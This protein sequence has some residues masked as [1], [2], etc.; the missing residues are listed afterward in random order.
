M[1]AMREKVVLNE[2]ALRLWGLVVRAP[3]RRSGH[4]DSHRARVARG[5]SAE[6]VDGMM[7]E[8]PGEAVW[9][10]AGEGTRVGAWSA[11]SVAATKA[12]EV[13]GREAVSFKG[14][15]TYPVDS[16]PYNPR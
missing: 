5:W 14:L 1:P 15:S 3:S 12:R 2:A 13:K 11:P 7:P 9:A 16:A 6:G 10:F 8:G 4:G